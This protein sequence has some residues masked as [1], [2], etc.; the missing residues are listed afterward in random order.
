MRAGNA[1]LAKAVEQFC[2]KNRTPFDDRLIDSVLAPKPLKVKPSGTSRKQESSPN[3]SMCVQ[4]ER[5]S[6]LNCMSNDATI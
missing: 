6:T 1:L 5:S 4:P 3:A 2:P